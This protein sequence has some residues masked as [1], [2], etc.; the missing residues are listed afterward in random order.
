VQLNATTLYS[1]GGGSSQRAP[2]ALSATLCFGFCT[3]GPIMVVTGGKAGS[4]GVGFL[5]GI[6]S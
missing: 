4:K 1:I 2:P 6:W 5:R 3:F